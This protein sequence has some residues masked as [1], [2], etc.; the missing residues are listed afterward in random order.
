MPDVAVVGLGDVSV[1]HLEAIAALPDARLV[2]VCDTDP[3][4]R[5]AVAG[6]L[7]VPGFADHREL[8]ETVRPEVLHVS[9]PHDQH[10]PV[11]LDAL[12]AGLAV[13]SEKPL[14]HTVAEGQRV[15]EAA[16]TGGGRIGVCFQNRYNAAVQAARALLV[17]GELGPVL[18]A[19]ATVL[20]HRT[21]AYYEAKPWRGQRVRS[22]G[23]V[24]I[25]QAIHTLDLL[26]WL[27]GDVVAVDGSAARRFLPA[28]IDVEDTADAVLTHAS[29]ARSVFFA[30]LA[31]AVDAPVA[32]E[33]VTERATL[34]LCG[35]LTVRHADGRVD[36]VRERV[37]RSGGRGYWGVSHELL[38]A[39]F[40]ARLS[41]AEPFWI[42][43]TEA[44]KSLR[45]IEQIYAASDRRPAGPA[46]PN[47]TKN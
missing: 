13:L 20:W 46:H 30:T 8:I 22:G 31:N 6:R 28:P 11:V 9:T 37:A 32:V 47:P 21:P 4:V 10:V 38:I 25:N 18:G 16:A 17:S 2:G 24:L 44:M 7:G 36:V 43:P 15:V 34:T 42:T 29:G 39:D 12:A 33:I 3:V 19:S 5:E 35:D 14:A 26:S 27:L 45:I 1:V 23:G 40:Y 41:D